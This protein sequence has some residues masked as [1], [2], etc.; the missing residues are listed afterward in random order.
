MFP[1]LVGA[2]PGNL[3]GRLAWKRQCECREKRPRLKILRRHGRKSKQNN[4]PGEGN[5][6]G[7]GKNPAVPLVLIVI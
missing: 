6:K 3:G 7:A 1:N 5:T 4:L 2:A